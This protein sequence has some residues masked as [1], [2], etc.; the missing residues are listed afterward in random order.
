MAPFAFRKHH[1]SVNRTNMT[2]E[3]AQAAVELSTPLPSVD[4]QAEMQPE[5]SEQSVAAPV[6]QEPPAEIPAKK[7]KK[8]VK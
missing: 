3:M 6:E 8:G 7:S 5:D 2:P 4:E 1:G